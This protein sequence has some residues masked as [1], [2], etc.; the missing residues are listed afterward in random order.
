MFFA[1]L[2]LAL[3]AALVPAKASARHTLA[4]R[5]STLEAKL[6]C[7]TRTPVF[8]YG[9]PAGDS[10]G[11]GYVW[12][13]TDA[14]GTVVGDFATSALDFYFTFNTGAGDP[15]PDAWLLTVKPTSGCLSRFSRTPKPSWWPF[16]AETARAAAATLS[17][18]AQ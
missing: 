7:M 15:P 11:P 16:R 17:A 4:H 10:D 3:L 18:R 9:D 14:D 12:D 6:A 8:E 13:N 5:V 2:A 1:V